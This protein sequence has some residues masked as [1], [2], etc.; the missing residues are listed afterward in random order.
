MLPT[1]A[2]R[3][4]RKGREDAGE[5]HRC[6]TSAPSKAE[7][8]LGKKTGA[9]PLSDFLGPSQSSSRPLTRAE[10]E[11]AH[12]GCASWAGEI[13]GELSQPGDADLQ[14]GSKTVHSTLL[15]P[16]I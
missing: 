7:D 3:Q 14:Q 10:V 9:Y 6:I 15:L 13:V 4:V 1:L 5:Q 12:V 16:L 11:V 8:S 2:A